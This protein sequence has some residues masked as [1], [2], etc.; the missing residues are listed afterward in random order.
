MTSESI[1]LPISASR[2]KPRCICKESRDNA[3]QDWIRITCTQSTKWSDGWDPCLPNMPP[4]QACAM[5]HRT[6]SWP[7]PRLLHASHPGTIW[8]GPHSHS[9]CWGQQCR[10][11]PWTWG[12]STLPGHRRLDQVWAPDPEKV[13]PQAG[14]LPQNSFVGQHLVGMIFFP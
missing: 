1:M 4:L 2:M 5:R 13:N 3:P 9:G 6:Q 10:T 7:H 14:Q 11:A 8:G 12:H